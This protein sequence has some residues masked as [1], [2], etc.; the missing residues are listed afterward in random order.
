MRR[1]LRLV[2]LPTLLVGA[3]A[4]ISL[5]LFGSSTSASASGAGAPTVGTG[6]SNAAPPSTFAP[7]TNTGAL[8]RT[9]GNKYSDTQLG[10]GYA[11]GKQLFVQSCSSCHGTGAEGTARA[12]TL[13]GL[14]SATV[15]FWVI[16]GRMPLALPTAQAL[17]K[18]PVFNNTQA[19]EIARYVASLSPGGPS[20]PS[21]VDYQNANLQQGGELYRLN[22]ATCH[23]FTANGGALSYGAFAP[24]LTPDTP[25]MIAEAIRTGPGNMP[26]FSTKQLSN[27]DMDNIIRYVKYVTHPEDRGGFNLGHVGPTTEGYVG[28]VFGVGALMLAA[29]WIGDRN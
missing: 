3:V 25:L 10:S 5:A 7:G 26:R 13:V 28:I 6:S 29:F 15:D 4:A 16:T 27:T 9:G 18:N 8:G 20:I 17:R 22:C 14:G 12:P 11:T 2:G 24:S 19:A 21:S 23:D 1:R